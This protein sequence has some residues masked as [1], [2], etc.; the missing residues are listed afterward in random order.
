MAD[1]TFLN[2]RVIATDSVIASYLE[3]DKVEHPT[4]NR[5]SL[6]VCVFFSNLCACVMCVCVCVCVTQDGHGD[7]ALKKIYA[8]MDELLADSNFRPEMLSSVA[9]FTKKAIQ[10][11]YENMVST[12]DGLVMGK[13]PEA[14]PGETVRSPYHL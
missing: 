14:I 4:L 8:S 11:F 2:D 12:I 1:N 6:L 3:D 13:A 5:A 10:Q 9:G 7:I